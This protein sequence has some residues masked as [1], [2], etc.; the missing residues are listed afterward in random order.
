MSIHVLAGSVREPLAG[1]RLAGKANP[2]ERLEATVLLRRQNA[3]AFKAKVAKLAAGD[4]PEAFIG[5]ADFARQFGASLVDLAAVEEFAKRYGLAVVQTDAARR[6]VMLSG[7]VARFERAFGVDLH[8]FE[9]HGGTYRGRTGPLTVPRRAQR[10]RRGRA[11]A[12]QPAP[13]PAAFP[14]AHDAARLFGGVHADH[15]RLAL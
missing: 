15:A 4:P 2:A 6:T 10:H 13:G 11:R 9:F 5:R 8:Q 1:A 14:R 3:D 12:R 7:T